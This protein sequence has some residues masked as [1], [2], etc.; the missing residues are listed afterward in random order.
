M[1]TKW[2]KGLTEE[3]KKELKADYM[4][5]ALTRGRLV[6]L[7]QDEIERSLTKMRNA[8]QEQHA[9]LSEFYADEL[10]VQRTLERVISYL[11]EKVENND[12]R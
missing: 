5:C 2:L 6:A 4:Q 11:T 1:N 9:N 7:I 12:G 8:A 3:Q 10:A